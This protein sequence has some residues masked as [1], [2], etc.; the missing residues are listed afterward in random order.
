MENKGKSKI[1]YASDMDRTLMFSKRFIDEHKTDGKYHCVETNN[2]TEISYMADAVQESLK[3]LSD[4]IIFV[5]VTSRSF[6]EYSRVNLGVEPEYAIVS[7]GGIL[8]HNGKVD[9]DWENY[10]KQ[11]VSLKEA[12]EIVV[13]LEDELESIAKVKVIDN[14]YIFCKVEPEFH[15]LY[16]QEALYLM[17]KYTNWE[18]TRQ[19]NKIYIVP[20]AFSKQVTLRYLWHRLGNPKIVA[21]GDGEMDLGMLTIADKAAIPDHSTLFKDGY[22]ESATKVSGGI[23]SPIETM[24]IVNDLANN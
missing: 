14:C 20:K 10:I 11:H 24:Q 13:D 9:K 16:D 21:S 19:G 3:G 6:D 5:P 2:G 1:I 15:T 4:N 8:L 17:S 7:N 22:V 23:L 18:F 12:M